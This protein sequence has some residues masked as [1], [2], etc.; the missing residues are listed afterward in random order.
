[1]T[2]N[3]IGVYGIVNK[4]NNKIYIGESNNIQERWEN[5]KNDLINNNHH[6]YKLQNDWNEYG[7]DNFDFK[8]LETINTIGLT[9]YKIQMEL[10]LL[11]FKYIKKYNS[12]VNGYNIE[13]TVL[14]ILKGEKTIISATI[15]KPYIYKNLIKL[16]AEEISEKY[17]NND[18]KYIYIM[19]DMVKENNFICLFELM[20]F[21]KKI[22]ILKYPSNNFKKA[23]INDYYK[24]LGLFDI[25]NN[26]I[27][28]S[29]QGRL[30][31]NNVIIEEKKYIKQIK[32]ICNY[33]LN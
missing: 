3:I 31:L 27:Y 7:I 26:I 2:G 14:K 9:N 4:L 12:I 6:S 11:E 29:E 21:L 13:N 23:K 18:N 15:D 28:I 10:I 5:H 8:I 32:N 30:Y 33:K 17:V 22:E 19:E 1:M 24:N 20:K 16:K 25:K